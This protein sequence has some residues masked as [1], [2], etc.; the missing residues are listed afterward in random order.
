MAAAEFSA[1]DPDVRLNEVM[2]KQDQMRGRS[3]Q[4]TERKV[5][6]CTYRPLSATCYPAAKRR[7]RWR[8]WVSWTVAPLWAIWSKSAAGA[9]LIPPWWWSQHSNRT[10][11]GP[12]KDGK[13]YLKNNKQVLGYYK[14][15]SLE[16]NCPTSGEQAGGGGWRRRRRRRTCL[17][18]DWSCCWRHCLLMCPS[19]SDLI[20]TQSGRSSVCS[21]HEESENLLLQYEVMK[22][23]RLELNACWR[24]NI[25]IYYVFTL[26]FKLCCNITGL[27]NRRVP[28]MLNVWSFF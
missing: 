13:T 8:E 5:S 3:M 12:T 14:R 11:T 10:L 6:N 24:K 4:R 16:R 23:C 17:F 21:K 27:L 7:T 25:H 15:E 9:H 18:T 2:Q 19:L 22:P 26:T 1:K 28:E 20:L